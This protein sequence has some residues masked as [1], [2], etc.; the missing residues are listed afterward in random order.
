MLKFNDLVL[1]Y[2]QKLEEYLNTSYVK[3]QQENTLKLIIKELVY[4][5][6]SYVKVQLIGTI[7]KAWKLFI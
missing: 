7:C 6:T 4:L 3:V 1:G 5:N 2:M